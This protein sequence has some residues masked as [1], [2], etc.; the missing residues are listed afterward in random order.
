MS[1]LYCYVVDGATISTHPLS[2]IFLTQVTLVQHKDSYSHKCIP[3]SSTHLLA[4]EAPSSPRIA[5][6]G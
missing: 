4:F 3:S 1:V 5:S 2:Y 6:I